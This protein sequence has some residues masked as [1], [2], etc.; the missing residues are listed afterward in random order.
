MVGGRRFPS[1]AARN[2]PPAESAPLGADLR[3]VNH[4]HNSTCFFH[5]RITAVLHITQNDF[6]A[7]DTREVFVE[8]NQF[9]SASVIY[10]AKAAGS[11]NLS[12]LLSKL[13]I[14]RTK[15]LRFK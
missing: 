11:T 7:T 2:P 14:T 6:P 3:C 13:F 4:V 15:D 10:V 12:D 5:T 1:V 9:K 8:D